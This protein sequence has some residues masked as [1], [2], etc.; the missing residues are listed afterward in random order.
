[1]EQGVVGDK[2]IQQAVQTQQSQSHESLE[3]DEIFQ[4]YKLKESERQN[5]YIDL[6]QVYSKTKYQSKRGS[7]DFTKEKTCLDHLAHISQIVKNKKN[8]R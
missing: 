4:N 6:K 3:L 1:M 5:P 7:F 8:S 2:S